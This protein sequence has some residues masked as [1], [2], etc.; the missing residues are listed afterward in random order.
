[1]RSVSGE[2]NDL[3]TWQSY[4]A[5]RCMSNGNWEIVTKA[6]RLHSPSSTLPDLT[7]EGR[8]EG[9]GASPSTVAR[10]IPAACNV[11]ASRRRQFDASGV[12]QPKSARDAPSAE[13]RTPIA[14]HF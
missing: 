3:I 9:H 7:W 13:N 4:N 6:A 14:S 5:C 1:M 10:S 2:R 8:N 12:Q 11:L